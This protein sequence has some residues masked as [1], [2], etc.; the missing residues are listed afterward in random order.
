MKA[1]IN[2][3]FNSNMLMNLRNRRLISNLEVELASQVVLTERFKTTKALFKA[4]LA[5]MDSEE[6]TLAKLEVKIQHKEVARVYQV[7]KIRYHLAISCHQMITLTIVN[8][9]L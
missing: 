1:V 9:M 6:Q 5:S 3:N 7:V 4:A 8:S 2:K